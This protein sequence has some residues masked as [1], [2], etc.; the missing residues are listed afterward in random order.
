MLFTSQVSTN[1]LESAIYLVEYKTELT[2]EWQDRTSP[3]PLPRHLRQKKHVPIEKKFIRRRLAV[4]QV[5]RALA[6]DEWRESNEWH[7][8]MVKQEKDRK[9]RAKEKRERLENSNKNRTIHQWY[10]RQRVVISPVERSTPP[11]V[12]KELNR[13]NILRLPV[14]TS[15]GQKLVHFNEKISREERLLKWLEST[16]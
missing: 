9:T 2:Y 8:V 11:K 13:P 15:S 14:Q 1:I 3:Q 5:T 16:Q 12:M 7:R 6:A 10:N 4:K